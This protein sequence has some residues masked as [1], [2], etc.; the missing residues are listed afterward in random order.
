M[1]SKDP[2]E[3]SIRK[4]KYSDKMEL[5]DYF[6][7][8]KFYY[9]FEGI[10]I[11]FHRGDYFIDQV[12]SYLQSILA[13]EKIPLFV[14]MVLLAN[15]PE[16]T[17]DLVDRLIIR[18]FNEDSNRGLARYPIYSLKRIIRAVQSI[19][20]FNLHLAE[21]YY[22]DMSP[23]LLQLIRSHDQLVFK[24]TG[25]GLRPHFDPR[26]GNF[27]YAAQ[28]LLFKRFG[29]PFNRSHFSSYTSEEVDWSEAIGFVN[30]ILERESQ[31]AGISHFPVF[32]TNNK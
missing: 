5:L 19:P 9:L 6:V 11:Y 22:W 15:C 3:A 20:D 13:R 14:Y 8:N 16:I 18:C 28:I 32:K 4:V 31:L 2:R 21:S 27:Y 29:I 10:L 7:T 24:T 1:E 17:E 12:S 26:R 25:R 23:D 30:L